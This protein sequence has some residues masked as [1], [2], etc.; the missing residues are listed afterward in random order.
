MR[1]TLFL[2]LSV[3]SLMQATNFCTNCGKPLVPGVKFCNNCGAP[4]GR[5]GAA[6]AAQNPTPAM[7]SARSFRVRVRSQSY[8]RLTGGWQ[9]MQVATLED[10]K[11]ARQSLLAEF[12]QR[13]GTSRVSR[14]RFGMS[15]GTQFQR[16][17]DSTWATVTKN[18][19]V[20]GEADL[21]KALQ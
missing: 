2:R 15:P 8:S 19:V 6:P 13:F 18:L 1:V 3:A 12:R 16:W 20:D 10:W 17:N 7:G 11:R 21:L 5:T 14:A 9:D 4:T